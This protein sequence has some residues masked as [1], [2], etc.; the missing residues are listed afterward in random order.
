MARVYGLDKLMPPTHLKMYSDEV[1]IA[2][3]WMKK[4]TTPAFDRKY[5]LGKCLEMNAEG[6]VFQCYERN[7]FQSYIVKFQRESPARAHHRANTNTCNACSPSEPSTTRHVGPC[8]TFA[9]SASPNDGRSR[10]LFMPIESFHSNTSTV[11]VLELVE[12]CHESGMTGAV[13]RE[14]MRVRG[15]TAFHDAYHVLEFVEDC[16]DG[17]VFKCR[18]RK[19][20]RS[21]ANA[22]TSNTGMHCWPTFVKFMANNLRP[23]SPTFVGQDSEAFLSLSLFHCQ[24]HVIESFR[25]HDCLN[26]VASRNTGTSCIKMDGV[27]MKK[28]GRVERESGTAPM[29]I[30]PVK[31][32]RVFRPLYIH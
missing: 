1:A 25:E 29:D 6:P 13:A 22:D 11:V 18:R 20:Q 23:S 15:T 2:R 27:S 10:A 4:R 31:K 21:V 5:A 16:V 17:P 7:T 32:R 9:L 26:V 12:E 8:E 30:S 3:F 28:R 19:R 24:E 14:K